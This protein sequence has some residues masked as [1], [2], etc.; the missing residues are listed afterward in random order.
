MEGISIPPPGTLG[1]SGGIQFLTPVFFITGRSFH[2]GITP[3]AALA[4]SSGM[5]PVIFILWLFFSIELKWHVHCVGFLTLSQAL[6]FFVSEI[7]II[8]TVMTFT[9]IFATQ[10][11]TIS[12]SYARK[13]ETS[14]LCFVTQEDILVFRFQMFFW[15]H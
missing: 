15:R 14:D 9:L 3:S 6:K 11:E 7:L 4:Q 13:H 10:R 8:V 12:A 2:S 1:P 5:C